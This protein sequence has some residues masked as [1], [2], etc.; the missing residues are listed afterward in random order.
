M[1]GLGG[2]PQLG[3]YSEVPVSMLVPPVKPHTPRGCLHQVLGLA[4]PHTCPLPR[5]T[6]AEGREGEWYLLGD[7]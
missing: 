4:H 3:A 7:E 2:H 1:E 6:L 5:L